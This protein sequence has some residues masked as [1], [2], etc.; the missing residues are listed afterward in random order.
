MCIRDSDLPVFE[1]YHSYDGIAPYSSDFKNA[2]SLSSARFTAVSYTHL[3]V[4][5]RQAYGTDYI[6]AVNA[7]Y[8]ITGEVP[9]V[10]RF[11]LGKMCIRDRVLRYRKYRL[12]AAS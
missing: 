2:V 6:G 8:K 12:K 4:Y 3:D 5:K 9:L 7:L 11:A 10:P 1:Q